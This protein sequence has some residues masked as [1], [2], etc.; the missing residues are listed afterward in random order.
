MTRPTL[1]TTVRELRARLDEHR[2]AR[3]IIGFVPTMGYL[4]EGHASLMREAG[5][6]SDVVMVSIFVN[7]LQFGPSEDLDSYPRDLD[8][9]LDVVTEAGVNLVFAPPVE[10]MYPKPVLTTVTVASVSEPMEGEVRPRHFAGVR[11]LDP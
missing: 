2:R 3:Q 5:R 1:V 7:P 6:S 4:H 9:D 10:E 11:K 8:R